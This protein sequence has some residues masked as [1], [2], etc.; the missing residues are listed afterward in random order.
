MPN[1][2]CQNVI[3]TL[4]SKVLPVTL[5]YPKVYQQSIIVTGLIIYDSA[6]VILLPSHHP[7]LS[8][9]VFL[10]GKGNK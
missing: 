7:Q 1:E 9:F 3:K 10:K 8:F 4:Q 2:N 6:P 5:I